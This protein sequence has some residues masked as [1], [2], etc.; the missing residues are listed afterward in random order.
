M[1]NK[2]KKRAPVRGQNVKP[3]PRSPSWIFT[4]SGRGYQFI[5]LDSVRDARAEMTSGGIL[6]KLSNSYAALEVTGRPAEDMIAHLVMVG[7][8]VT[9]A[10]EV[11]R[12]RFVQNIRENLET[13]Y[14]LEDE[15]LES[16][17]RGEISTVAEDLRGD[18]GDAGDG[19]CVICKCTESTPCEGNDGNPCHW[20]RP[21]VLCSTCAEALEVLERLEHGKIGEEL[22]TPAER[23]VLE[24][25]QADGYDPQVYANMPQVFD[26]IEREARAKTLR[27][28]DEIGIDVAESLRR[29][30][31]RSAAA[32]RVL[33]AGGVVEIGGSS[34][35][36]SSCPH[37]P[38]VAEECRLFPRCHVCV[39]PKAKPFHDPATDCANENKEECDD[40]NDCGAVLPTNC[41]ECLKLDKPACTWSN[42]GPGPCPAYE[43]DQAGT[44]DAD[45]M[46]IRRTEGDLIEERPAT[47]EEL[48][49]AMR[50]CDVYKGLEQ[51]R[52]LP[53]QPIKPFTCRIGEE[54]DSAWCKV[55]PYYTEEGL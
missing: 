42:P 7:T 16:F 36:R 13:L 18:A 8:D 20:T 22:L 24:L 6:L 45:R 3:P 51:T 39:R 37:G 28:A 44:E 25:L 2:S 34:A 15:H 29:A 12:D 49:H 41:I 9:G 23:H 14:V 52:S 21:G 43:R 31:E 11:L 53:I 10:A 4:G 46:F 27:R 5:N 54:M 47:R 19:S 26:L 1:G 38:E 40:C 50:A 35:D 48:E 32:A 30:D 55:C 33:A 17:H